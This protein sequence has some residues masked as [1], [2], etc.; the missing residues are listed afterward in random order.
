[1]KHT[2]ETN[3][4]DI[5]IINLKNKRFAKVMSWFLRNIVKM[6]TKY[7]DIF[8]PLRDTESRATAAVA[9]AR[10]DTVS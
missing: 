5:I 4:N 6:T 10:V 2:F 8:T 7:R 1:M 9:A 3:Y